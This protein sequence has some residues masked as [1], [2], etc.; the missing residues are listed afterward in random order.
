MEQRFKRPF[1]PYFTVELVVPMNAIFQ[2]GPMMWNISNPSVTFEFNMLS[3]KDANQVKDIIDWGDRG[4]IAKFMTKLFNRLGKQEGWNYDFSQDVE[5]EEYGLWKERKNEFKPTIKYKMGFD[6]ETT[7]FETLTGE[8]PG[9]LD[10]IE[11][12]IGFRITIPHDFAMQKLAN[13]F[14]YKHDPPNNGSGAFETDA[15]AKPTPKNQVDKFD[16]RKA[17]PA[18]IPKKVVVPAPAKIPTVSK[19]R[20]RDW[21]F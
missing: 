16:S 2:D 14:I 15:S 17:L 10:D 8:K 5:E 4:D 19:S 21:R 20:K 11:I 18:A 9:D 6:R 1:T 12:P 7:F 3:L 13:I